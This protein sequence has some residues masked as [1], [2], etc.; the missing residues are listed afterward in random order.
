MKK[1]IVKKLLDLKPELLDVTWSCDLSL[2]YP[3]GTCGSCCARKNAFKMLG[4]ND[5]RTYVNTDFK[6]DGRKEL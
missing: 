6:I 5:P 2:E 1:E 4:M 3:C